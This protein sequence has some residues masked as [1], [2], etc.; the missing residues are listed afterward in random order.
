MR[1]LS[2]YCASRLLHPHPLPI[3]P[4]SCAFLFGPLF[5]VINVVYFRNP[6]AQVLFFVLSSF[7]VHFSL[8]SFRPLFCVSPRSF[9]FVF[10]DGQLLVC[11]C[12]ELRVYTRMYREKEQRRGEWESDYVSAM[13][14]SFV[15]NVHPC[16]SSLPPKKRMKREGRNGKKKS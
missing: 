4:H 2:L 5:F 9:F 13:F 14:W 16:P 11:L 1:A 7:A 6:F 15:V 3:R 8:L 12:V 10:V